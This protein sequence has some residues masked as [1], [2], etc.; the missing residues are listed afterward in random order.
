M[1]GRTPHITRRE[2]LVSTAKT[3]DEIPEERHYGH[4]MTQPAPQGTT[5]ETEALRRAAHRLALT[6]ALLIAIGG[7]ALAIGAFMLVSLDRWP[8]WLSPPQA[9][10]MIALISV[11][12][13]LAIYA[14]IRK[15]ALQTIASALQQMTAKHHDMMV[16]LSALSEQNC[17]L[18]A[19]EQALRA[20][21]VALEQRTAQLREAHRLGQ[22]GDWS[23]RIGDAEMW[24]SDE[25]KQLLGY[26]PERFVA[27]RTA[28]MALHVGDSARQVLTSQAQVMR[29]GDIHSVDV[30]LRRGDGTIGDFAVTSKALIDG[31]GRVIG[32]SGTIQDISA[33]KAAEGQLARLA[34]FDPLTGLANRTSFN[35]ETAELLRRSRRSGQPAALLL[36]DLD[37]FEEINDT[38]G[39]AA[40]NELLAKA[41]ERI[42]GTAGAKAIVSRLDGDQFGVLLGSASLPEAELIANALITA[43]TVPIELERGEVSVT[44]SIGIAAL[45]RDGITF[46]DLLRA[47]DLARHNAKASGRGVVKVF[48]PGMSAAVQQLIALGHDLRQA[49]D[50]GTGL[51]VQYQP[52]I[53]LATQRVV[54]HAAQAYWDHPTAGAQSHRQLIAIA[55][56]SGLGCEFGLWLLREAAV[57]GAIWSERGEPRMM[58][59]EVLAAQLLRS[60]FIDEI[61]QILELSG[62]PPH[63]LCLELA[64][65][66]LND[67]QAERIEAL[68]SELKRLDVRLRL[69]GFG[70]DTYS[71]RQLGHLPLDSLAID[72]QFL[73]NIEETERARQALQGIIA[74]AHSLGLT[75]LMP[76]VDHV[77]HADILTELGCDLAHGP[78]FTPSLFA[79]AASRFAAERDALARRAAQSK[80]DEPRRSSAC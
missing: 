40:A 71:I 30:K 11:L 34:F 59:V 7:P 9:L 70:T 63:L 39:H 31:D 13:G 61:S 78:H 1:L 80:T 48:E 25:L 65:D 23:Y 15:V 8:L 53:A 19:Q 12:S 20:A 14:V 38:L 64:A 32:F 60:D 46:T 36:L 27:T 28:V 16:S 50:G 3:Y 75:V 17:A 21:E 51:Q 33:R 24:C 62:L 67:Q 43:I 57:Q 72:P 52:Q 77:A 44:T 5:S 22:I 42:A 45:P 58:A 66:A 41:A 37:G 74:L 4:L 18:V 73:H 26:D 54:A 56:N 29:T 68:L 6:V 49:L 47:A 35:R 79:P 76:D 2:H 55:E 69:N 10:L